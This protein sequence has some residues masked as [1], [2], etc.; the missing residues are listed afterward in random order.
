[1]IKPL[2]GLDRTGPFSGATVR[3]DG[4]ISLILDVAEMIRER[5]DTEPEAVNVATLTGAGELSNGRELYH[6]VRE[7]HPERVLTMLQLPVTVNEPRSRRAP[8]RATTSGHHRHVG[9]CRRLGRA[10]LPSDAAESI[11]ALFC[12][13][14]LEADEPD[15]ADAIGELVNMVAAARR[16]C[17]A[18]S[19]VSISCPSRDRAQ[20]PRR[21][22]PQPTCRAW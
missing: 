13:E 2:D 4:G 21:G 14:Q 22:A 8:R 15:F 20:G 16:R 10:E 1:V 3:N 17:S 7:E 12:G 19:K 6:P 5:Q 18:T 9:R 11:V